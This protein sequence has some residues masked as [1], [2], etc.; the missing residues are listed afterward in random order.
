MRNLCSIGMRGGSKGVKDKNLKKINGKP[1]LAYTIEQAIESGLFEHIVVTTD[2][3]E[4]QEESINFGAE[5][6]FLRPDELATDT[7]G[8]LPV[9]QHVLRE[10]EEHYKK[11]FDV[12]FDLDVTAPLRRVED[13]L[14]AYK[15]LIDEDGDNVI[16]VCESR[17]N[18][19][20]N[21]IEIIDNVPRLSKIQQT[22]PVRRQDSPKVFDMNTAIFGWRTRVKI[23][24]ET[25]LTEKTVLYEMPQERSVDIDSEAD[26]KFIEFFLSNK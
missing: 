8:K 3:R 10:S 19:Y 22:R 17:K 20:F 18:P 5:S 14:G 11:T 15:K 26:W 12:I 7:S 13:I 23:D 16:S 21:M 1:L 2:S 9:I 25:L 6:W 24:Y 4:I